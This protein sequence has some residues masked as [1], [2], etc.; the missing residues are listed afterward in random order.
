MERDD[1]FKRITDFVE[2]FK[3]LPGVKDCGKN[4][5]P[6]YYIIKQHGGFKEIIE[7]LKLEKNDLK[8][9]LIGSI[10][11][12]YKEYNRWPKTRD[13]PDCKYLYSHNMYVNHFDSW[14]NAINQAAITLITEES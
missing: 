6:S 1:L 10:I 4:G 12:Y 13:C 3:K 11:K 2:V 9:H 5:I 14:T 7:E 8:P